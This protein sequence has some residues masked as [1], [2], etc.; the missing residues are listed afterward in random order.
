MEVE[1]VMTLDKGHGNGGVKE[2]KVEGEREKGKEV[3]VRHEIVSSKWKKW[4]YDNFSRV[5][6]KNYSV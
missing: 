2:I 6:S 5:W 4:N 1:M 3:I